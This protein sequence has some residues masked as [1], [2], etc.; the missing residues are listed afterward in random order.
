MQRHEMQMLIGADE[1][2]DHQTPETFANVSQSDLS[3][4]EKIFSMMFPPDAR[5]QVF[6]GL[7]KY[8]NRNMMDMYAG[9]SRGKEQW[10]VRAAR[11]LDEDPDRIGVGPFDFHI[12]EPLKKV[13]FELRENKVLPFKFD[14]TC[15]GTSPCYLEFADWQREPVGFRISSDL[16]RYH[17]AIAIEGWYEIDGE[18]TEFS[19]E[20]MGFRTHSWGVRMDVG[21]PP[22]DVNV[23]DRLT[24]NFFFLW[25]PWSMKRPDGTP[26]TMITHLQEVDGEVT[27]F[28]GLEEHPDGSQKSYYGLKHELEFDK[29]NRRLLGGKLH[30]DTGWG[31]VHTFTVEPISDTGL[32]YGPALYF[33]FKGRRHGTWIG[34]YLE[35][36]EIYTDC[37]TPEAARELHQMQDRVVRIS[38]EEG[39]TGYGSLETIVTGA[40]PELGLTEE[41]SY[42]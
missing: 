8:T 1:R 10:T 29:V 37:T 24:S 15:T 39:N 32:H 16:Q 31:Q 40:F 14:Y 28:N 34:D 17:Q 33:G 22:K 23:P 41:T 3:W 20:W 21:E 9:F 13:R 35:D 6:S 25:G 36:G 11:R 5:I 4:T 26:F 27:Y 2:L 12:V 42:L 7:G 38:D 19:E 18:R 30:F